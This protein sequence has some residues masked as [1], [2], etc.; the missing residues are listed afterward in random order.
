MSKPRRNGPR[1]AEEVERD[2]RAAPEKN[3]RPSILD[4][5]SADPGGRPRRWAFTAEQLADIEQVFAAID[6]GTVTCG[7]G[8][9]ARILKARYDLPWAIET[10]RTRLLELRRA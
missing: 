5:L 4:E 3:R 2:I 9:L 6:A 7:C 8:K 1:S 10:I